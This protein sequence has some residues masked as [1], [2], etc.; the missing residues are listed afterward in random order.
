MAKRV[1]ID[2]SILIPLYNE[3]RFEGRY[4]E[5][6]LG[7]EILFSVVTT[8]ELIRGAHD[9]LSCRLVREFL[10]VEQPCFV[11]PSEDQWLQCARISEVILQDKKRS[12][13]G[14][15]LL[16]NDILIALGARDIGATLVTCDKKDFNLLKPYIRVPIEFW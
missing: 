10:E 3:R 6:N 11:T 2:T 13:E 8:N 12:K 4:Q 16:Q 7:S 1:L 14:V 5:L 9:D 15:L